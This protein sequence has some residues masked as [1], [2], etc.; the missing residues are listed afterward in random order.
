M[1]AHFLPSGQ[2]LMPG[3]DCFVCELWESQVID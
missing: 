2:D 1:S 3:G